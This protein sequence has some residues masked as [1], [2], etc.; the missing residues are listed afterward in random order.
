MKKISGST[1]YV[2]SIFPGIWFGLLAIFFF[3]GLLFWLISGTAQ[4]LIKALF[5]FGLM[6]VFGYIFFHKITE[7]LADEVYDEGE[8]LL[9]R[10][11][12]E[13]QRV[14]FEEI[15]KIRLGFRRPQET[16]VL[17]F[18]TEGALGKN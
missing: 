9:F 8:S 6:G 7:D 15:N 4:E 14:K 16:I 17:H 10:K 5:L 18:R 2:K 3:L 12:S 11:G 13:E 1:L